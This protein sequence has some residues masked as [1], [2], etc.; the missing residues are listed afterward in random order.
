M[1]TCTYA[2]VPFEFD[3]VRGR[4]NPVMKDISVRNCRAEKSNDHDLY[5]F[6]KFEKHKNKMP[7]EKIDA[8]W[9][10]THCLIALRDIGNIIYKMIPMEDISD[11]CVACTEDYSC[12]LFDLLQYHCNYLLPEESKK[13]KDLFDTFEAEFYDWASRIELRKD[14]L[15]KVMIDIKINTS[16]GLFAMKNY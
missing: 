5:F 15:I 1:H 14:I 6:D 16:V 7:D 9:Q 8:L 12:G 2:H 10:V 3:Y 11:K 13:Y 4:N